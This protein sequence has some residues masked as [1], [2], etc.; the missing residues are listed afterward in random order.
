MSVASRAKARLTIAREMK[1]AIKRP[2][3][4]NL[5]TET[6]LFSIDRVFEPDIMSSFCGTPRKSGEQKVYRRC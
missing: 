3:G 5:P 4:L 1:A 6:S 2:L